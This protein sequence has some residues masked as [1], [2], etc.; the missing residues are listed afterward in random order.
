MSESLFL[1]RLI[2]PRDDFAQ[3]LTPDE[4]HVMAQ[5]SQYWHELLTAGR[6]VVYGPVA[7]PEG[8]WGLGI[9]RAINRAEVIELGEADPSVTA[10]GNTFEVFEIMGARTG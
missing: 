5:H 3:T 6:V 10:G 1:F 2:P 7:D 9:V 8:V 4:Q